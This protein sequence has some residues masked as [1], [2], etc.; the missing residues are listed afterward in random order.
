MYV[1]P[2]LKRQS[3]ARIDVVMTSGSEGPAELKMV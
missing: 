2:G 1:Q 3:G